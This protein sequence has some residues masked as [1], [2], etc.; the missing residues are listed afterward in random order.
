MDNS[1]WREQFI[2]EFGLCDLSSKRCTCKKEMTFIT[3]LLK[4]VIADIKEDFIQ[5]QTQAMLNQ[6]AETSIAMAQRH[7]EIAWQAYE[8]QLKRKWLERN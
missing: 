1:S 3:N 4:E 2:K 6:S 8:Y 7:A 5:L